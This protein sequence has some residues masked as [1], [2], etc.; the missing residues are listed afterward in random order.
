LRAN[1]GGSVQVLQKAVS[2]LDELAAEDELTV[3][4]LAER[5]AEPRSSVYRLVGSLRDLGL[6]RSGGRG[7]FRLGLHLL[8]LGTAVSSRF[9]ERRAALPVMEELGEKTN[10]T[11][12]L[13]LRR[14]YEAV[15]IERIDGEHVR[16]MELRLGGALPLHAGGAARALLAWMPEPFWDEYAER[17]G[18]AR[19]TPNTITSR[20]ELYKN[21][22]EARENGYVV[23]DG[24]VTL[25]IAAIG[26]PVFGHDGRVAA[27][28]SISGT[29]PLILEGA[30]A[31]RRRSV[32][33]AARRIS[34]ELG[35]RPS[36]ERYWWLGA[37]APP[38]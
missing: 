25:G 30:F 1:E 18:L 6:V 24:D 28:I 23:S 38:T 2:I 27:S 13:C 19:Y 7:R 14:D 32:T 17:H 29:R 35:W 36:D 26:A 12:F 33:D 16:S 31:Q 37:G 9:D 10:E 15:C 5:I 21:L 3:A 22:R 4:E 34:R 8:E 20:R 11:I